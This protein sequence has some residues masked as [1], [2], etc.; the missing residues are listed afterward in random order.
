MNPTLPCIGNVLPNVAFR[1]P[2]LAFR[3]NFGK[4][5]RDYD[6]APDTFFTALP[7]NFVD[8]LLGDD[9]D[10]HVHGV[11]YIEHGRVGLDRVYNRRLGVDRENFAVEFGG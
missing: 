3:P 11:G 4:A 8:P 9:N 6:H 10:R 1:C 5:G 2:L 7:N